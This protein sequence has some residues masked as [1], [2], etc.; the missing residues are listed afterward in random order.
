LP[1]DFFTNI[2]ERPCQPGVLN[3]DPTDWPYGARPAN[4]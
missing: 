3:K 1:N 4:T 2:F